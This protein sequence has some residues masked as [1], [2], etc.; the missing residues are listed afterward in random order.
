[1]SPKGDPRRP[2]RVAGPGDALALVGVFSI[3]VGSGV[4]AGVLL[5]EHFHTLPLL[6]VVGLVLGLVGGSLAVY[7]G[8][9]PFRGR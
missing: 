2:G 9:A 3:T 1:M 4:V 5:D 7:R 8:L 6:T